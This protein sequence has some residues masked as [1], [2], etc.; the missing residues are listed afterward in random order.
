MSREMI[1]KLIEFD[2]TGYGDIYPIFANAIA[3]ETCITHLANWISH[4]MLNRGVR[5]DY[6]IGIES[7]GFIVASMICQR[8]GIPFIPIRKGGHIPKGFEP[9]STS[10][11]DYSHKRKSLETRIK[12]IDDG[13]RTGK[14]VVVA[15]DWFETGATARAAVRLMDKC[16]ATVVGFCG[17]INDTANNPKAQKFLARYPFHCILTLDEEKKLV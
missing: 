15:D 2:D 9:V 7:K 1:Y 4:L 10:L 11:V 17:M 3:R 5:V 12:Y 8:M 16:G 14:N 6:I 13:S